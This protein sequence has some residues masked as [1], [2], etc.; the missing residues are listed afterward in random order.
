MTPIINR[1][2]IYRK[3]LCKN[4]IYWVQIRARASS[5]QSL[6]RFLKF[7]PVS[8]FL[9]IQLHS[10]ETAV[11]PVYEAIQ[12]LL[13]TICNWKNSFFVHVGTEISD[14]LKFSSIQ[15]GKI[16]K[17][18]KNFCLYLFELPVDMHR[19]LYPDL[20]DGWCRS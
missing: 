17:Q 14:F 2:L 3:C 7:I 4:L 15:L 6:E 5:S 13:K 1:F 18:E 11:C 19:P 16:G 8:I 20:Q 10:H 12:L 9:D